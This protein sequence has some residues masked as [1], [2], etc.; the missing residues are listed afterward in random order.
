MRDEGRGLKDE[1]RSKRE[2][3]RGKRDEINNENENE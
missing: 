1:V 3:G 2:E